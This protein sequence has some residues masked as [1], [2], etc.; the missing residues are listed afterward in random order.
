MG[1]E[2][3]IRDS[4]RASFSE[5]ITYEFSDDGSCADIFISL[6]ET[7]AVSISSGVTPL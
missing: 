5:G 4:V 2:M 3:C 6:D 7:R 1:S